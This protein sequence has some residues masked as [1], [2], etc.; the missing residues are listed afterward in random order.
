PRSLLFPYTTLFRSM[1]TRNAALELAS[2]GI[3]VNAVLPGLIDTPLT[4]RR[5]VNKPLM[6]AW[7]ERIPQGRPGRPEEV[8]AACLFLAGPERSEEHTSELQSRGH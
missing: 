8:A 6:E 1:F 5:L 2:D 3:R 7:L 4:Q